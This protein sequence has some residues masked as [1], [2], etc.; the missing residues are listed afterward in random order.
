[1]TE[2]ALPARPPRTWA[3]VARFFAFGKPYAGRILLTILVCLVASGAKALQ[4]FIAKPL[5]ENAR[6]VGEPPKEEVK[7]DG[8]SW[9]R[10]LRD[11]STWNVTFMA[12]LAVGT[13]VLMFAFGWLRDVMTTWLRA[14]VVADLRNRVAEHLAHVP[15]R[16]HYDRR[17][18][19]LVSRATNDVAAVEP[20][21]HF[22]FGDMIEQ[23][24]MIVCA[25]GLIFYSNWVLALVAGTFFLLYGLLLARMARAMRKARKSSMEHLGDMTGS[26]LQTFGGIKV[27]KAFNMEAAQAEEVRQHNENY[28]RKFMS[29]VRRKAFSEN[30]AQIFVGISV[31]VLLV[32]GF[33]L[34]SKGIMTTG[35]MAAMGLAVAMINS[36]VKEASK[37]YNRLIEASASCERIFELLDQPRETEHEGG[38][39]IPAEGPGVEYRGVTFAYDGSPVLRD[40][41][42]KAVPGDVVAV[43]GRTGAGKTTLLDLLCRFYDPQEGAVL[44]NGVDLKEAS[45]RSLLSRIAVVTQE[46]FL[47]N[48]SVGE[49]IRYGKRDAALA[50][51]EAAAKAAYIHDFIAGLPKGYDTPVGERGAKVSG[52]QRQRLTIARAILR[53]PSILIL[54][55]ATSALDAE[56]EKAVQ[57]ALDNLIRSDTRIT[58]VIA[59][60]LSTIKNAKRIL[61]LDAGKVVEEGPH[62]ALLAREGVY[63]Q[64]YRSQFSG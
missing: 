4:A 41:S 28:F 6:N 37:S 31:A 58:F 8:G 30:L 35:D 36:S 12:S 15:L 56:S 61:V 25:L 43:V 5:I 18:G 62:E 29:A 45:R 64:L 20:A 48:T 14:R 27:V 9:I 42:F 50:E 52:G 40:V 33:Q 60:R 22:L 21:A 17:S 55:E 46:A 47:F 34:L 59:H 11:T 38:K 23:P 7:K 26:M 3:L 49:N 54:D 1:M 32:G 57:A 24:V 13:S 39:P 44:V 51:V 53:N 63:A 19:D 10:N 2:A 16:Y